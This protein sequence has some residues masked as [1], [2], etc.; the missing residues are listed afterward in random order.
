MAPGAAA[1]GRLDETSGA[2]IVSAI[3]SRAPLGSVLFLSCCLDCSNP[4]CTTCVVEEHAASGN[5]TN[6]MSW[7]A[8]FCELFSDIFKSADFVNDQAVFI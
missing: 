7:F 8:D 2:A 1:L 3:R 5:F 4:A 6:V